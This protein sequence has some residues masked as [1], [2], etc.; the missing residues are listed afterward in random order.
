MLYDVIIIGAG[1]MG[2][3]TAFYL[4]VKGKKCI[5]VDDIIDTAGTLCK[6]AKALKDNGAIYVA[7]YATHP[8]FSGKALSNINNSVLDEV[9]VTDTIPIQQNFFQG[10]IRQISIAGLLGETIRRLQ[11]KQ[12]ISEIYIGH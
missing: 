4:T 11:S 3:S 8:V 6:A 1:I 7:A 5:I 10:C 2:S 12:S 9:V